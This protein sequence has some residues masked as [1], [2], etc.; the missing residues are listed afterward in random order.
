M[1]LRQC[2]PEPNFSS[3]VKLSSSI[4]NMSHTSPDENS[5]DVPRIFFWKGSITFML[6]LAIIPH[7]WVIHQTLGSL[8]LCHG[9]SVPSSPSA[10]A[11]YPGF[12]FGALGFL[13]SGLIRFP[14]RGLGYLIAVDD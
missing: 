8:A 1:F 13:C 2:F 4:K 3:R 7:C 14:V 9:C 11:A 10:A 5:F 12:L 6:I